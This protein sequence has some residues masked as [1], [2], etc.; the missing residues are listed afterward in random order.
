MNVD[1]SSQTNRSEYL[2]LTVSK[3]PLYRVKYVYA[4]FDDDEC[5]LNQNYAE[6][7]VE[8][9]PIYEDDEYGY[10]IFKVKSNVIHQPLIDWF[11]KNNEPHCGNMC[12]DGMCVLSVERLG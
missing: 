11:Q 10:A 5:G 8:L 12:G 3:F 2:N 9:K 4:L 1:S 6:R 7:I